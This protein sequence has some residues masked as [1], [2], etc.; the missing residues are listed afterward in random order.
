MLV[1]C[2]LIETEDTWHPNFAQFGRSA[3]VSI[4]ALVDMCRAQSRRCVC[5]H[6]V[7]S[8]SLDGMVRAELFETRGSSVQVHEIL[9]L[10]DLVWDR[11]N[12]I[13]QLVAPEIEVA[14]HWKIL[15]DIVV[16]DK[17]ANQTTVGEV[18]AGNDQCVFA[19]SSLKVRTCHG[20]CALQCREQRYTVACMFGPVR[21]GHKIS[22]QKQKLGGS[23]HAEVQFL[24]F[25]LKQLWGPLISQLESKNAVLYDARACLSHA[26]SH[27]PLR[28]SMNNLC[29]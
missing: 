28:S 26:K 14:Q 6:A 7:R 29:R 16:L 25:V 22:G 12:S 2:N 19:V 18:P 23:T 4:H 27:G 1:L 21:I 20:C 17:L 5:P 24:I 13:P 15:I 11:S 3:A 9:H 8:E 10:G